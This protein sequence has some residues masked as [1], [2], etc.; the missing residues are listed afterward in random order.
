MERR[1]PTYWYLTWGPLVTACIWYSIA[2]H[3]IYLERYRTWTE[4]FFLGLCLSVGSYGLFDA[5]FF[6]V[7]SGVD[8][9]ITAASSLTGL[10]FATAFIFLYGISLYRRFRSALLLCLVPAAFFALTFYGNMF[11]GFDLLPGAVPPG[12]YVPAYNT[13]WFGAWLAVSLILVGVG[14]YG[15]LRT[16]LEIRKQV[17]DVGRRIGWTLLGFVIAVVASASNSFPAI[18][19]VP[20]PPLFS[21]ALAIPGALLFYASTPSALTRANATLLR[22]KAQR[23]DV[24]GAFLT[25]QDGTIIGSKI[26]PKEET[27]DP[28]LFS[29]A[30]DVIQNFMRTSFPTLGGSL[31]AIR[32]GGYTLVMERG[33]WS[34]L[35]I[36]L[37]GEENDQLRRHMRDLLLTYEDDNEAVLAHWRGMPAEAIG[38]EAFL[39]SLF[40][41]G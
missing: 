5:I 29:Q 38:T 20:T 19:G 30:L 25:Y 14:L 1:M 2:G 3:L 36:I 33:R 8:L 32:Q 24:K 13:G 28:D 4:Y 15:I 23:Y 7:G 34:Y 26:P 37:Q 21:T 22:R 18:T 11:A 41:T 40:E 27:I 12:P 35:T 9:R 39:G 6:S 17:P 31:S 10:T 16:Y